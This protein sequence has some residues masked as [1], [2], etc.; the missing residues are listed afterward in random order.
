[1]NLP[2][3]ES[4]EP[5]PRKRRARLADAE[6]DA[7]RKIR[8]GRPR[9]GRSDEI[10]RETLKTIV[11]LTAEHHRPPTRREIADVVGVKSI[12]S[13][14]ARCSVL[15]KRGF[16]YYEFG[17]VRSLVVTPKGLEFLNAPPTV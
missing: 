15:Y 5:P 17:S 12:A 8:G 11:D 2:P 10:A 7:Q 1:M 4:L 3:L 6:E 9:R 14:V 16:V 13:I